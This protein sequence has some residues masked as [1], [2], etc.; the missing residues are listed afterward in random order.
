MNYLLDTNIWLERMLD[1]ER[2]AD[3]AKFLTRIPSDQLCLTDFS[4][5]SIGVI[6][7]R[8]KQPR[9]YSQFVRDVLVE[10][11]VRLLTVSPDSMTEV[12]SVAEKFGLDFDDAYQYSIAARHSLKI[13]SLDSDFDRTERGRIT[14]AMA[15]QALESESK[16]GES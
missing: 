12:T 14:P 6:L 8:L 7:Y 15:L 4:L 10:G 1:Q 11:S 13:V 2:T 16:S 9:V 5:H 3:V